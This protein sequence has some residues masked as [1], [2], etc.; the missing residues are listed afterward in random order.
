M[1]N[2][3]TD[4]V[5][6]MDYVSNGDR[7]VLGLVV[8]D[9]Y[10]LVIDGGNSREHAN[11]LLKY[12]A[13]LD[14]PPIKYLLLTHWHWDHVFGVTT[15]GAINIVHEKTDDKLKWMKTLKW[16][17][18]AI[19]ERVLLGEEIK[20]CE[21]HMKIEH[22]DNNRNIEIPVS[23]I[24]FDSKVSI[25]IGGVIV[26]AEHIEC[27]HSEDCVIVNVEGE[28][29]VFIGDAMYNDMY[30]GNYSYT[31]EKLYWLIDALIDIDADYYIP[32]HHDMYTH[33]GF[34]EFS[35]YIKEVGDVVGSTI[36][37]KEGIA[38]YE[39]L[40]ERSATES[41]VNDIVAFIEGNKKLILDN[42]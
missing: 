40:K 13:K 25:D 24:V 42:N 27:D 22:P 32:S 6:Y 15:I 5:Y 10:S 33:E 20:F 2:K 8:G 31:R 9:D 12:T 11:E 16:T 34:K 3:L 36:S 35:N 29:V 21:D 17:D 37:K 19:H 23:D 41:E 1:L 4:R 38:R 30:N 7:P 26:S 39:N 28:K 14:I 18:K